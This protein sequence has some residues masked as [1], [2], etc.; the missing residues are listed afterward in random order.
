MP[1]SGAVKPPREPARLKAFTHFFKNYMSLAAVVTAS[2]PI[3]I[4]AMKLIP[5]F[6]AQSKFLSVYASLFCF[7]TLA[8]L[9]QCRHS[10]ARWMFLKP[11]PVVALL[12]LVLIAAALGSAFAYHSTIESSI[13]DVQNSLIARGVPGASSEEIL[14]QTDY[15]EIPNAV[16][17]VCLYLGIFR[18]AES[19]FVLMALRE[20]L[21]DLLGLGEERLIR[22]QGSTI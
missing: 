11:R 17:L 1:D 2:L 15:L 14:K 16:K 9:F 7:L 4:S 3:P 6:A 5:A 12:P 20:Y 18:S 8:F 21:Q 19:A 22:N 10:L 13:Q